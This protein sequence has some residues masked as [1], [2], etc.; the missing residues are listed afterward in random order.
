MPGI[1]RAPSSFLADGR[2]FVSTEGE[3]GLPEV[4]A[5][6]GSHW[7]VWASDYPHWD[8]HFPDGVRLVTERADLTE[9]DKRAILVGNATRLLSGAEAPTPAGL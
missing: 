7:I 6:S 5:Q 9:A 2:L 4:I 8:C 1:D 3:D